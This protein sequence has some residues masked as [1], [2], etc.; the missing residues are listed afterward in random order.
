[1][2]GHEGTDSGVEPSETVM[3]S[4]VNPDDV[5]LDTAED[6]TRRKLV[7]LCLY[8]LDRARSAGV[9]D[10]IEEGLAGVGVVAVRPDGQRF[11]PAHHEAGGTLPTDDPNLDGVVAE[12][13]VV[14]FTDN[15]RWLRPPIVTVYTRRSGASEA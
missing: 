12:T 11:D 6:D 10:R 13:E 8:A 4:L 14:G 1:M 15:G 7:Q 2:L 9:A 5:V 3:G